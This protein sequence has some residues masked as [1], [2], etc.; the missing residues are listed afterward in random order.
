MTCLTSALGHNVMAD[1]FQFFGSWLHVFILRLIGV[2][3]VVLQESSLKNVSKAGQSKYIKMKEKLQLQLKVSADETEVHQEHPIA[4]QLPEMKEVPAGDDHGEGAADLGDAHAGSVVSKKTVSSSS[5]R[6]IPTAL[7]EAWEKLSCVL[8][9][10]R[11]SFMCK[12][13]D[14]MNRRAHVLQV[15]CLLVLSY[16]RF[17]WTRHASPMLLL[18]R[19]S[20]YH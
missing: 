8:F 4:S 18:S 12:Q 19:C 15:R 7:G 11:G 16:T 17:S 1:G 5:G 10:F 2:F 13:I 9:Y 3:M 6:A 20:F 14:M